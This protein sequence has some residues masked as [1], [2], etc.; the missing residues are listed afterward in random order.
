MEASKI[1]LIWL[2][3]STQVAAQDSSLLVSKGQQ[4]S[5]QHCSRCHV[6]DPERPFTGIA[7]TPSFKLMVTALKDWEDRFSSFYARLPHPSILRFKDV[8]PDPFVE[9]LNEPVILEQDDIDAIV[10]YARTFAE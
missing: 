4:I 7:S 2:L 6:V 3:L 9:P 8:E 5:L 1:I 10:A